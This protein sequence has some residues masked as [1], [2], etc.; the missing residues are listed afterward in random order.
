MVSG[1]QCVGEGFRRSGASQEFGIIVMRHCIEKEKRANRYGF[2]TY[3]I[4]KMSGSHGVS[5]G[6]PMQPRVTM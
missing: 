1:R 4:Y 2:H 3:N 5:R 6:S